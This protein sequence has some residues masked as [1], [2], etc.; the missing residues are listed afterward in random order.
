M[1]WPINVIE[2][3][4]E[5]ELSGNKKQIEEISR[6]DYVGLIAAQRQYKR[7]VLKGGVIKTLVRILVPRLERGLR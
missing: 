3:L 5:A 7:D 1:T 6:V 4:R 2:E